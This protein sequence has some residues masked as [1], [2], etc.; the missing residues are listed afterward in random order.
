MDVSKSPL[1]I[2]RLDLSELLP[3]PIGKKHTIQTKLNEIYDMYCSQD[4]DKQLLFVA[5]GLDGLFVYNINTGKL[6]WKVDRK[7]PGMEK[8]MDCLGVTTD[9]RGHLFVCDWKNGNRCIHLFRASDG[10][11]LGCLM[12]DEEKLG[13][14]GN[15]HWC[16]KTSSLISVYSCKDE[17][18]INVISVKF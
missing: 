16:K 17:W 15:I 7:P 12:K 4:G 2:Q 18:H 8:D 11:Y 14:P 3:K 13:A 10:Q 9:K 6:E 1:E 5:A